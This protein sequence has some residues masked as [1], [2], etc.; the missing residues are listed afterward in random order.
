MTTPVMEKQTKPHNRGVGGFISGG[1]SIHTIAS[2]VSEPP[3]SG[4]CRDAAQPTGRDIHALSEVARAP[5]HSP[6]AM[7]Q[8]DA[9]SS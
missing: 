3:A 1:R 9:A 6:A 2:M 4:K 7:R 8:Y 5:L